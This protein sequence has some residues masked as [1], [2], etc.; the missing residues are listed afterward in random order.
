MSGRDGTKATGLV[1]FGPR[2][3]AVPTTSVSDWA[4]CVRSAPAIAYWLV[5]AGFFSRDVRATRG[6][7]VLDATGHM[8]SHADRR[9]THPE[10]VAGRRGKDT[11]PLPARQN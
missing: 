8:R 3:L 1:R 10:L 6:A 11:S 9:P 4:E 2:A 5:R 7:G